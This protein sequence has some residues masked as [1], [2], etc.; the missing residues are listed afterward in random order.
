MSLKGFT[1]PFSPGGTASLAGPVPYDAAMTGLMVHFR[2]D[3]AAV[4]ALIPWPLEP[5]AARHG[6]CF[7]AYIDH[8]MAPSDPITNT[9]HPDRQRM[10]EVLLGVACQL[11]GKPGIYYAYA[12]T[13]RDWSLLTE[14]MFGWCGKIG[15]LS[16]T[17]MQSEHPR[18][19]GPAAGARYVATVERYGRVATAEVI[20]EEQV[21]PEAL[22][23]D[24]LL[25]GYGMRHIPNVDIRANGR[26]LAHDLVFEHHENT[27][28][29]EIWRGPATLE[30]MA[31][32][33]EELLPIQPVE[34]LGGYLTHFGYRATG[35]EVAYDYLKDGYGPQREG[36][37]R[38]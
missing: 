34:V 16:L 8:L 31:N 9:W 24:E 21:G 30:F 35:V 20:L 22:P 12:W 32:E 28:V 6:E 7:W 33:N 18:W 26:P 13:D 1:R 29:G 2:A 3:P 14:W 17:H 15:K 4:D 37:S 36:D 5:Y 23:L 11:N 25:F 19:K 10:N 27:V 38:A